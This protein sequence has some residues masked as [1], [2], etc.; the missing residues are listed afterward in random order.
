MFFFTL[1]VDG[2]LGWL[3]RGA[4]LEVFSN[5]DGQR[6]AAWCYGAA[7]KDQQTVIT[8]VTEYTYDNGIKL[9]VATT[10]PSTESALISV[11]DVKTS[12][13]L[14][15]IEIPYQ[16]CICSSNFVTLGVLSLC[17]CGFFSHRKLT[18]YIHC[19]VQVTALENIR[20]VGG[21]QEFEPLSQ[22]LRCFCG[23][24]AVGTL[25][26]HIYLLGKYVEHRKLV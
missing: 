3:V 10:T 5:T 8:A 21:E 1:L 16:V 9:L 23:I 2:T 24:V 11:F 13:I 4:A 6:L 20:N 7:L 25:H 18:F 22:H 26:G 12:K 15:S 14:K 17:F 19:V